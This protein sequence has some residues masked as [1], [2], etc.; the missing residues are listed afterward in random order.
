MPASVA[1]PSALAGLGALPVGGLLLGG[2]VAALVAEDVRVAADHLVGD[3]AHDVVPGEGAGLLGHAGVVDDLEQQVAELVA[4][5]AHV[6]AG[7]R[8]GD[9]VG[10]LDGVGRD[11]G[12]VLLDVPRAAA[13]RVAQPRH[14]RDEARDAAVRVVEESFGRRGGAVVGHRRTLARA[15]HGAKGEGYQSRASAPATRSSRW[16][17][18]ASRSAAARPRRPSYGSG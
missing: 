8:L 11:R 5:L 1:G 18:D 9:L 4:E 3:G 13:R 16:R 10:L 15:W 12:E 2:L 7:D 17:S 6:A 14:D